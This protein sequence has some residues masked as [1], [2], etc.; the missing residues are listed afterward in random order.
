MEIFG[1]LI[2]DST[3]TETRKNSVYYELLGNGLWLGSLNYERIV[4]FGT[5]SGIALRAGLSWYENFFPLAGISMLHG[6]MKHSI[7]YGAGYTAFQEGNLVFLR[8][9]Y[10]YRGIGGLLI[11]AAPLYS[12]NQEFFWFGI[13]IGYSF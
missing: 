11:R 6:N 7:E 10:R 8:L 9:G 2:A 4:P 12:V 5:N 3:L 1:A 13:S